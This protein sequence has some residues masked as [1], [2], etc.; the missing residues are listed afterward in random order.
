MIVNYKDTWKMASIT[1][2][3][4]CAVLVC[5]LFL[6]FNLDLADAADKITSPVSQRYYDAE[7][8]TGKVTS[9]LSGGC[10]LL[11]TAVLL[12]FYV[13]HYIDTHQ[14]ELGILKALGY[15][16]LRIARGFRVFGYSVLPGTAAAY[17]CA[18][19]LMPS[20]YEVQNADGFLPLFD[21]R[22]HPGLC[23][24]LV[25][26]PALFFS[27]L[28]VCYSYLK[29]KVSPLTL[30]RGKELRKIVKAKKDSDLPFLQELRKSNVRQRKSLLFFI[31]F[32]VFCFSSMMQMSFSMDE[33][34]SRMMAVMIMAIG[35][36]LACVTLFLAS[37]SV[38]KANGKTITMMKV[39]GYQ[40]ADCSRAVLG[41][42]RPWAY[43]GFALGSAY[44]YLL[45]KI[46]VSVVF[47]DFEDIPE[48]HFDF[49]ACLLTLF[50]FAVLYETVMFCYTKKMEKLSVKEIML[51]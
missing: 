5:A 19:L 2:I 7:V 47:A 40:S 3:S 31:T 27:L 38:V 21:A 11:T 17:L 41:G 20:F 32:A 37:T 23:F 10:L 26:L 49:P 4:F 29:L 42:Y 12:C 45:L 25:F 13:G 46:M 51:E 48:Y 35:I 39:F 30:L 43:F 36:V 28:A 6:N 50:C 18:H 24:L 9:G 34:A 14:K 1:V 8:M 16:R 44:Q 22:F 33:L 15:S